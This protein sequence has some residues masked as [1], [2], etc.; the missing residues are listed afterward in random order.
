MEHFKAEEIEDVRII[1]KANGKNYG[2]TP[3]KE[4][5]KDIAKQMRLIL[6]D[7]ALQMHDI[8]VPALEDIKKQSVLKRADIMPNK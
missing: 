8:V 7:Y 1:I 4:I 6:G 2:I 5:V 3:K